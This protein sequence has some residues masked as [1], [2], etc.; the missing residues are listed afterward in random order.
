MAKLT[1]DQAID[2]VISYNMKGMNAVP[3][4]N[5]TD[6]SWRVEVIN[7]SAKEVKPVQYNI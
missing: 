5:A 7:D 1:Q 6:N 3:V 4:F 2:Q